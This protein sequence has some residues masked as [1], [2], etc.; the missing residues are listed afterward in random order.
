[1]PTGQD[2]DLL[3]L[4]LGLKGTRGGAPSVL[5]AQLTSLQFLLD[6]AA[7][8]NFFF[9]TTGLASTCVNSSI[10]AGIQ[11]QSSNANNA[12]QAT[13]ANLCAYL[14][15]QVNGKPALQPVGTTSQYTLTASIVEAGAYTQYVVAFLP[16]AVNYAALANTIGTA[17]S[18]VTSSSGF[19]ITNDAGTSRTGSFTGST[20]AWVAMR[21][22]RD[23]NN[24]V[25]FASSG[26]AETV[27]TSLPGALTVNNLFNVSGVQNNATTKTAF[28]ASVGADTVA[29]GQDAALRSY[30]QKMFNVTIP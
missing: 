15:N 17:L 14:T 22:R 26:Q 25:Y 21:A 2:L 12:T 23:A 19:K 6:T 8:G 30:I 7:P 13:S 5:P 3:Y 4:N 16:L 28:I 29:N 9:Q 24:V 1:M 10:C 11:D 27:S 18:Y 20:G